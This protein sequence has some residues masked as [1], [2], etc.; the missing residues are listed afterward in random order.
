MTA[1]DFWPYG[2]SPLDEILARFFG[3][4]G[5]GPGVRRIDIGRLLSEDAV[6]LLRIPAER[7]AEWGQ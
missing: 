5:P 2:Y 3:D 4:L 1:G 7:A 6:D